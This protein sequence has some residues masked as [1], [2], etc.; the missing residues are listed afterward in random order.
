MQNVHLPVLLAPIIEIF[1]KEV[2]SNLPRLVFD[3]TFGGG[4]Y[5]KQILSLSGQTSNTKIKVVAT[6]LDPVAEELSKQIVNPDFNFHLANFATEIETFPN[7]SLDLT[8]LDLGFSSNQ[9]DV[10]KLGFSYLQSDQLFDLR[11]NPE[12]GIPAYEYISGQTVDKLGRTIFQYSGETMARRIAENL[13]K[14]CKAGLYT[15]QNITDA[16]LEIIPNKL[17]HKK[18][19]IFS[20]VWQAIRIAIN[21]EFDSLET[22]LKIAPNKIKPAGLIAIVCFH[23]LEDKIVTKK[24]REMAKPIEIDEFGN[25][26]TFWKLLTSHPIVS[27]ALELENNVRSRSATLRVIQKLS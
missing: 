6:D 10:S 15:N 16:I 18:Y 7:N 12:S 26:E 17:K 20:R 9:L 22:F 2:N 13:I 25:K 11:F 19:S 3:G 21:E 4:S 5:S 23:S 14:T 1:Q 8:V 24:F 27:D